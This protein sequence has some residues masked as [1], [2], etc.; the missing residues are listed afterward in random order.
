MLRCWGWIIIAVRLRTS[1]RYSIAGKPGNEAAQGKPE[2]VKCGFF[3]TLAR[4]NTHARPPAIAEQQDCRSDQRAALCGASSLLLFSSRISL[5][6]FLTV[7]AVSDIFSLQYMVCMKE[8]TA[9][10]KDGAF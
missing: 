6:E 4:K 5:A 1:L 9:F 3:H 7:N 10:L 8:N 2:H